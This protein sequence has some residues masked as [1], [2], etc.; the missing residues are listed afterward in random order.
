MVPAAR[1]NCSVVA[2]A[3]FGQRAGTRPRPRPRAKNRRAA[4]S[5][6]AAGRA[7]RATAAQGSSGTAR[8]SPGLCF[9]GDPRPLSAN[10]AKK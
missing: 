3:P 4:A 8:V 5:R 9:G 6:A 7:K 1:S 2:T 10:A